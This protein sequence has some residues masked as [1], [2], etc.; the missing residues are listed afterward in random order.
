MNLFKEKVFIRTKCNKQTEENFSFDLNADHTHFII[1]QNEK[2]DSINYHSFRNRLELLFTKSLSDGKQESIKSWLKSLINKQI[3][4]KSYFYLADK[5]L[6]E[7][8]LSEIM[9]TAYLKIPMVSL[10]ICG[11]LSSIDTIEYKINKEIPVVVLKGSGGAADVIGFAFDE[12][13]K[14]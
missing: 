11:D 8:T 9:E 4:K 14:K 3:K 7:I 1:C 10:I 2:N 6:S 13:N 12:I 5:T